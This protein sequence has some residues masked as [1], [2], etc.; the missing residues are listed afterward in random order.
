[1]IKKRRETTEIDHAIAR[2]ARGQYGHVTRAQLLARGMSESGIDRAVRT[3][4]LIRV[5][6]G[7]YAVGHLREDAVARAMAAVLAC[8]PGAVLSHHSAAALW[9]FRKWPAGPMHVTAPGRHHRRGIRAHR[10]QLTR[11]EVRTHL[12]IRATSP[13]RT[14]LDIAPTLTHRQLVRAINDAQISKCLR[15]RDLE[16]TRLHRFVGELSRS[17][18]EDHFRPWRKRYNVPEPQYNVPIGPYEA[19]IYYVVERVI[20]ELDGWDFHRTKAAFENDR[21]RDAYMLARGIVTVRITRARF[22]HAPARE[23]AR[24]IQILNSRRTLTDL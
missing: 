16:G 22:E 1:V 19:D 12:G 13:A 15:A 10:C 4:R 21:E 24:L 18:F 2:V 8:G 9:G 7:V 6:A 11:R 23:A 3:G 17:P 14:L 5:H 20:V